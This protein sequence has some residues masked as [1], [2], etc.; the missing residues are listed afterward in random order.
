MVPFLHSR[1]GHR[2]A[3]SA[4]N[5]ELTETAEFK[6]TA[7]NVRVHMDVYVALT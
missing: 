3:L 6:V 4:N 2:A 7:A 5:V 1:D